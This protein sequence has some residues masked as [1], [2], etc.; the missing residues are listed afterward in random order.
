M[1]ISPVTWFLCYSWAF[2]YDKVGTE[3]SLLVLL[4]GKKSTKTNS[5]KTCKP[6]FNP[7]LHLPC[8]NS[9]FS[10]CIIS[11]QVLSKLL[12][13]QSAHG[14]KIKCFWV[15][16][17]DFLSWSK[18]NILEKSFFSLCQ[19]KL[20]FMLL[21]HLTSSS[22]HSGPRPVTARELQMYMWME[23]RTVRGAAFP[24]HLYLWHLLMWRRGKHCSPSENEH[25]LSASLCDFGKFSEEIHRQDR[26][27]TVCALD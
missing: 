25:Q 11:D 3:W 20:S 24:E 15:W 17:P 22:E 14:R 16:Q 21:P 7:L 2:I 5:Q 10:T 27:S 26:V 4:P 9:R 6:S 18:T 23:E 1:A 19:I 13:T 8:F 12:H